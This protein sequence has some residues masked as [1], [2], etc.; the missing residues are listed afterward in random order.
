[1]TNDSLSVKQQNSKNSIQYPVEMEVPPISVIIDNSQLTHSTVLSNQHLSSN[2]SKSISANNQN[3]Y[4]S[5]QLSLKSNTAVDNGDTTIHVQKNV[6][7]SP[8]LTHYNSSANIEKRKLPVRRHSY[9]SVDMEKTT[10]RVV[11][12]SS[13]YFCSVNGI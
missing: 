13:M 2:V 8:P 9:K 1:M 5:V 12:V 11:I 3:N 10:G 7:P 6:I 4:Q